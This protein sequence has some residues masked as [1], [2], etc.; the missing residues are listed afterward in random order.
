MSDSLQPGLGQDVPYGTILPDEA[1]IPPLVGSAPAVNPQPAGMPAPS[2]APPAPPKPSLQPTVQPRLPPPSPDTLSSR[3]GRYRVER[4]LKQ[5][6]FGQVLLA[7][8]DELL[9]PVAIKI[10]KPDRVAS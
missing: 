7:H 1:T 4:V 2:P 10:P 6:G 9:R 8:D 3:I 5:G